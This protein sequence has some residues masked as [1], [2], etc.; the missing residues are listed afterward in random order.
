MTDQIL[1]L[2]DAGGVC[3]R[4]CFFFLFLTYFTVPAAMLTSGTSETEK[5]QTLQRLHMLAERSMNRVEREIK[6][7]YV[8]VRDC[9]EL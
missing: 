9:G 2:R 4:N 5:K 1:H 6:L 3:W 7:I 8:T